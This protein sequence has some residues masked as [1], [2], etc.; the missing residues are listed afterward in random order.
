MYSRFSFGTPATTLASRIDL[1]NSP[2]WTPRNNLAP[3][4]EVLGIERTADLPK[5]QVH[6]LHWG[7]IRLWADDPRIDSGLI[8]ARSRWLERNQPFAGPSLCRGASFW[9][10]VSMS[11]KDRTTARG[12]SASGSATDG[13]SRSP[14]CGSTEREPRGRSSK[15]P[16][17]SSGL[18]PTTLSP[19]ARP[20]A[21]DAGPRR[22]RPGA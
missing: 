15:N 6:V 9:R 1:T 13:P 2:G 20:E 16:P 3:T 11:G 12:P 14:P 19:P 22:L 7:L 17:S 8:N 4:Q 18:E 10:T 21:G 5:R